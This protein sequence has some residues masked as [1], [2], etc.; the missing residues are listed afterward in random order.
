M[1][2][3][4]CEHSSSSRKV[5]SPRPN[6]EGAGVRGIAA[7]EQDTEALSRV[8]IRHAQFSLLALGASRRSSHHLL[9]PSNQCARILASVSWQPARPASHNGSSS[10]GCLDLQRE[11]PLS[12][13]LRLPMALFMWAQSAELLA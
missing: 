8:S 1:A 3:D 5:G 7:R 4:L 6:G 13:Q 2:E 12:L 11:T 9:N 10:S